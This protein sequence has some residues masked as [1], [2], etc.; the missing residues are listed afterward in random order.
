MKRRSFLI[1]ACVIALVAVLAGCSDAVVYPE[2]PTGGFI[3]QK[4][5]F[6]EGQ[7]LDST[8]FEVTATYTNGA[9]KTLTGV[10]I[11]DDNGTATNGEDIWA[12]VGIDVNGLDVVADGQITAY[13]IDHIE[14]TVNGSGYSVG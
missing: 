11:Q 4:G 7:K 8:K 12:T 2:F 3:T 6:L 9:T 13:P 5:D 10:S 14:V 1:S